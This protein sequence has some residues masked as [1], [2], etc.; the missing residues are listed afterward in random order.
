KTR[1]NDQTQI[2]HARLGGLEARHGH[3]QVEAVAEQEGQGRSGRR[4][5]ARAGRRRRGGEVRHW[6]RLALEIARTQ[7][8]LIRRWTPDDVERLHVYNSDPLVW[9]YLGAPAP[10]APD[11]A[12][13]RLERL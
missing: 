11:E 13:H 10:A 1:T 4:D 2:H 8:L 5:S 9:R 7:R 12:C 3:R 6:R